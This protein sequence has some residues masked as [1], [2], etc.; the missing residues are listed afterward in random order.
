MKRTLLLLLTLITLSS[1]AQVY[2]NEWIDYNKTYYKFKIRFD[3]LYRIHQT[4]L[5]S[6]GLG[7]V[8]ADHFQIWKNGKQVPLYTTSQ[9]AALASNG[10]IEL[11]GTMNDGK[12]DND[13]YRLPDYQLNDKWSLQL[14]TAVYFLT[15]NSAG[16]NLRFSPVV[17]NVAGNT[18]S[19]EPYFY[20]TAGQYERSRI[21]A[22]RAEL[23]G[24]SY[25]YSSSYDV[26]EGWT[27]SDIGPTQSW[28]VVLNDLQI[29]NGTGAP[30]PVVKVNAAG[31]A[32]NQRN[33]KVKINGDSIFQRVLDYY[34]YIK[35]SESFPLAKISGNVANIEITNTCL[36]PAD[37]IVVA[38]TELVYP[39]KFHMAS[40]FDF[41]FDL[42]PSA[43]GNY[44]EITGFVHYGA[45]PAIYDLTNHKRYIA[46]ISNPSICKVVLE[47]SAVK[48]QMVIVAQGADQIPRI[49]AF[50]QANF[51]NYGLAANQG[52]YLIITNPVLTSASGAGDPVEEYRAYRTS[53]TGGGYNARVYMIDQ[54]VDQFA[55]GIRMHP[56]AIR[57]FVRWA[58]A[59]YTLP[60]KDV[61]LIGKGVT[62]AQFSIFNG[63]P[64]MAKLQLVPTF[65][66]PGSD[67]LLT[68]EGSSSVPLIPIGRLSVINKQE[69]SDYLEKVKE[70]EQSNALSS[71]T[72]ADKGWMKNVVHVAGAG[73]EITSSL[74]TS[75]LNGFKLIVEDTFYAG[76]VSSFTK[77]T[78]DAVSQVASERLAGLFEE[79]IGFLTYFGH[80]SASS[81]EFNMDNP[82]AYHNTGKYP[83][84]NV[85]GC[86]A[87]NFFNYNV[88]RFVTKET[89]SEKYVLAKQKGSI[90]FLASTHLGIIHYLDIYG[91]RM[92]RAFSRSH[93]GA[94]LG[95]IMD[96]TIKQ[97]FNLTTENDFYSR[98]HCE[99]FTLHGDPAL[100]MHS[101]EKPDYVIEDQLVNVSPKIITVSDWTFKV[102]AQFRNIGK[103]ISKP[104]VVETKRT[105]P[106][107]FVEVIRR[108]TLTFK[109]WNDSLTYIIPITPT[110][111]KG[112]NKITV[113]I[114]ADNQVDELYET[115]NSVTKD[116]YILEDEVKPVYPYDFSIVNNQDV[117]MIA[118]SANP[119]APVREYM[120][121][122]DT[123]V[124]FNSTSKVV[125]T[126]NAPGGIITF[127]PGITFVDSTVY[128]WR[129]SRTVTSGEPIWSTS[130]FQYIA[131]SQPGF[132]QAHY[133]QHKIS[134]ADRIV[135]KE[136]NRQ[137]VYDSIPNNLFVANGVWGSAIGQ[138]AELLVNVNDSSYIRSICG[139]GFTVNVFDSKTFV[140]W[141]NQVVTSTSGLYN[142]AYPGCAPSRIYNFEFR[143]NATARKDLVDFL[144]M[145]PD[146]NY[147]V[148]RFTVLS[149]TT[150]DY[151]P[152]WFNDEVV[153]GTGNS[154]YS[155]L[156]S[157]G[158]S[159]ID[160]INQLRVF[161]FVYKKNRAQEH[162]PKFVFSPTIFDPITMRVT[163]MT[164]DSVG[165]IVSPRMGPAKQ[166]K[167][168][169]WRGRSVDAVSTDDQPTI[170]LWGVNSAGVQ[171]LLIP[172]IDISKQDLDISTVDAATYPFVF[173]QMSNIDSVHYTPYQLRY[174]MLNYDPLPEGAIAPNL[175]LSIKDTV[176]VGEPYNFGIGF[177]NVSPYSFDSLKVKLIVTDQNN[178]EHDFSP[179]KQKKLVTVAPNDSLRLNVSVDTRGLSG[180]NTIF[181]DFNPDNHQPEQ[182]HFNNFAFRTLYVKPDSLNPL[183]D[184]TFDGVHIL[185]RDIVAAK[186]TIVAKL[187]DEARW[188][189]LNDTSLVSV[190]IKTPNGSTRPFYFSNQDTLQFV[191][192]SQSSDNTA[193][194]NFKPYFTEDGQYELIVKGKDRSD[195]SAGA[196]QYR[197]LFTVINKPMISNMLNYPNPFTT[198]T[199]FVFTLTGSEVPQNIRIQILTV[200]GKVVREITKDELGPIHIGRNITEFKWDGTDQ[201]GQKL[202]NGVYLYRVITNLNGKSLDKYTSKD[203]YNPDETD[204]Y[205]NKGYGK[206]YLMR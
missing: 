158:F 164:P 72:L 87:G 74:L 156:K 75:S 44:L 68:S 14:D 15:V 150:N 20:Y 79:G 64:E 46:D 166:W 178:S 196:I 182:F 33:I 201:Y 39:R 109:T 105:Y 172:N 127:N 165:I 194:I 116:V 160:S 131:N 155:E 177:K 80:S 10:Y 168:L 161:N 186:P 4:D 146:G 90:A 45:P 77:T 99:Q 128:Y 122:V 88:A 159:D 139:F 94:T 38:Q 181:I 78:S 27:T 133:D 86:N 97:V 61:F 113:T 63:I 115:N 167:E 126:I 129:I 41:R 49:N 124:K 102:T 89:L 153:N 9:N 104:I 16:G 92:Y 174:W 106:D 58:R 171:T 123:S 190:L 95:E 73:D 7:S 118:S 42:E 204:K 59:N 48:R 193:T 170:N 151:A 147:V 66:S 71:P 84:F 22:G 60:I 55:F 70:Y 3:K 62:Y 53:S 31:N 169:H 65:G 108:D 50:E 111:D 179:A 83:I 12:P 51:V 180:L 114:D 157:Q 34:D 85:M 98:F 35:T 120:M 100:R 163:C 185:N 205:F 101:F 67:N 110:K 30:D 132:S 18:L 76:H 52:N 1:Q 17:N 198:S 125:R 183:L 112:L 82:E 152:Q 56:M 143:N 176:E 96:E 173:L 154:V 43:I 21:N 93:Y 8:N 162:A 175:Y 47:P 26:G 29:Y 149:N 103:A 135:L 138:E 137:W 23:V 144:R 134:S 11:W 91:T 28:S 25:T 130:S 188:M 19:P 117:K 69:I 54:L 141:K 197:V 145:I 36:V 203:K 191:P 195:N 206:M 200:T 192:A 81:L 189:L 142:S 40:S 24:T 119:F 107:N 6:I 32:V 5:V 136:E 199:A 184:V 2:N 187:K 13:L 57:N 37:R 148:V 140:P 202:G 121:E